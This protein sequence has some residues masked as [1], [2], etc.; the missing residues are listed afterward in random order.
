MN[1]EE[2]IKDLLSLQIQHQKISG[3][4]EYIANKIRELEK[5]ENI[6]DNEPNK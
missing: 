2:L 1:K 6:K 4:I 5:I 3:A